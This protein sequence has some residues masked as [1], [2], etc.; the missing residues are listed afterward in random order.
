MLYL[1]LLFFGLA[2]LG[3]ITLVWMKL[4][5]KELPMYLALGHG[6]LAATGLV[7]LIV[8]VVM[9]MSMQLMN[10]ALALFVVIALGGFTLFSFYLRKKPLPNAL[11]GI[12]GIGAVI[13]Y[14]I[15]L[16]AVLR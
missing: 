7:L 11:I 1:P 14:I 16:A 5:G 10:I 6:L 9:D 15:L 2:A 4:K 8:N 13:S 3:G 12:H